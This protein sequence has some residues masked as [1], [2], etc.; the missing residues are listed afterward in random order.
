MKSIKCL[1]AAFVLIGA[2]VSASCQ[3]STYYF[4]HFA[5]IKGQTINPWYTNDHS[6]GYHNSTPAGF[7]EMVMG[8]DWGVISPWHPIPKTISTV[9]ANA[10]S[11]FWETHTINPGGRIDA[12]WDNF[13][14]YAIAT[15]RQGTE[16]MVWANYTNT[17]PLANSYNAKGQANPS[18]NNQ[19]IGG[20]TWNIYIYKHTSDQYSTISFVD[21][22]QQ[23][24]E[25]LPMMDF[26]N[27]GVSHGFYNKNWYLME[28]GA[29]WEFAN[30]SATA[31]SY[32]NSGY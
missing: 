2:S 30:G 8:E 13:V 16:I 27:W 25:S 20:R 22:N 15:N 5:D 7:V 28:I 18:Y 23:G 3:S 32:G 9:G 24:G 19:S 1:L 14:D 11:W 31:N 26:I 12:T 4:K 6:W 21:Q 29:G 17:Q 10:K